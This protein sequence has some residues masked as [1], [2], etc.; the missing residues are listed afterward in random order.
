MNEC[1]QLLSHHPSL[2][3]T[4]S[5]SSERA[6]ALA[7]KS[8]LNTRSPFSPLPVSEPTDFDGFSLEGTRVTDRGVAAQKEAAETSA[9]ASDKTETTRAEA[10]TT[11]AELAETAAVET[12]EPESGVTEE[13]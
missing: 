10:A 8:A 6:P 5:T 13:S 1:R 2:S 4:P 3:T 7:S 12:N 9:K 11:S